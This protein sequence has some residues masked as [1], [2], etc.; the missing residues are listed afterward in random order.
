MPFNSTDF[1]KAPWVSGLMTLTHEEVIHVQDECQKIIDSY[2]PAE[3]NYDLINDFYVQSE[4]NKVD[5]T[6]G[7]NGETYSAIKG[8]DRTINTLGIDERGIV[9]E[10]MLNNDQTEEIPNEDIPTE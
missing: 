10:E 3:N 1:T 6:K 7:I 2:N 4:Y 9:T 8:Y 5:W